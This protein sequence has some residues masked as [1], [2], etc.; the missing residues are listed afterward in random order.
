MKKQRLTCLMLTAAL[1]ISLAGC[2]TKSKE[3]TSDTTAE[4]TTSASTVSETEASETTQAVADNTGD[5]YIGQYKAFVVTSESLHDGYWDDET[6]DTNG[7][8][9]L[10]PQLSW[11]PVEGASCY[12]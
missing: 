8:P 3:T 2:S 5:E 1:V 7:N 12:V 11:D 10:S 9:N 4:S 6:S